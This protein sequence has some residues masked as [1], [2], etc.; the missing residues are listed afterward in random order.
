MQSRP[1]CLQAAKAVCVS[2]VST[3]VFLYLK[4]M[5]SKTK[6]SVWN[7]FEVTDHKT[8]CKLC[9]FAGG[10]TSSMKHHIKFKHPSVNFDASSQKSVQSTITGTFSKFQP[11]ARQKYERLTGK[12]YYSTDVCERSPTNIPSEWYWILG[13]LSG[14]KSHLQ[15]SITYNDP[16]LHHA[17][18]RGKEGDDCASHCQS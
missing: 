10:S 3:V 15:G 14:N 18:V 11:V 17:H 7:F 16:Q 2:L 5:A 8:Q 9:A 12:L 13:I 1:M 4:T 6:S